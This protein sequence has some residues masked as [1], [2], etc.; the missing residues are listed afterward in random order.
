MFL[1]LYCGRAFLQLY[2]AQSSWKMHES[3]LE[4]KV[5]DLTEEREQLQAQLEDIS[6]EV[7]LSHH[8][9]SVCTFFASPLYL[10][11]WQADFSDTVL[12]VTVQLEE[13]MV[14]LD[15][16]EDRFNRQFSSWEQEREALEA[17]IEA[18]L[19]VALSMACCPCL[20]RTMVHFN[21][22]SAIREPVQNSMR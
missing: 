5:E 15:E 2:D 1:N 20:S 9:L 3:E 21:L 8:P 19:Q 10:Q 11:G 6:S 4:S 17:Q 14:L 12:F 22:S 16:F 18:M 7:C 13:K